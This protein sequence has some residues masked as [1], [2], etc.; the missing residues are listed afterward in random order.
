MLCQAC[1]KEAE[2]NAYPKLCENCGEPV[3]RKIQGAKASGRSYDVTYHILSAFL[4]SAI[5]G[6]AVARI[7]SA[8]WE[9]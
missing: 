8:Y 5:S 9:L 2:A 7:L 1:I 3:A 4:G 6:Y